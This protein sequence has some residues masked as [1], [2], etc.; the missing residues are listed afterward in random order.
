MADILDT[1]W[2]DDTAA[3]TAD[4]DPPRLLAK[5]A[6]LA[7]IIINEC[8]SHGLCPNLKKGKSAI[9][10]PLRGAGSRKAAGEV[11]AGNSRTLAVTLKGGAC[12]QVHV[13]AAYVHLG[14]YLDK[15]GGFKAEARRRLWMAGRAF[16]QLRATALQNP[17]VD[18]SARALLFQSAVGLQSSTWSSGA[19]TILP[20][21][22][23][24]KAT[25]GYSDARSPDASLMMPSLLCRRLKS[26]ISR[27]CCPWI[28]LRERRD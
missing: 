8:R 17:R 1:T 25:G 9:M 7:A 4:A 22:C 11:F 18:P 13:E 16:D 23:Y 19:K 2:A 24:S 15:D 3:V 20:G 28:C 12:V 5:A 27:R 26:Y 14:T 6:R 10:L 21:V